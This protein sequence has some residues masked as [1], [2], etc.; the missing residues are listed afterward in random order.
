MV[1]DIAKVVQ[2][3]ANPS[4]TGTHLIILWD[5][6]PISSKDSKVSDL[7]R[8]AFLKIDSSKQKLNVYSPLKAIQIW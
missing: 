7:E 3:I 8:K 5:K 2:A 4:K 1:V 6:D